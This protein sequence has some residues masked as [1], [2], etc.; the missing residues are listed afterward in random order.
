MYM[1]RV[2]I[3]TNLPSSRRALA[4]SNR[5]HAM[6]AGCF[7]MAAEAQRPLWRID[8]LDESTYLLLVSSVAPDF[9]VLL[10]QL[11]AANETEAI[12]KDYDAFLSSLHNGEAL[13]FRITANPVHSVA[14]NTEN[15]S[16]GKVL[17]HVTVE[18]QKDWLLSRAEK[19]GFTL[20]GFDVV[21]RGVKKFQRQRKTVT[22][23]VAT[24][25]GLLVVDK[26]EALQFAL[27][28]GLGRAKAYGCG[29]LTVARP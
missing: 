5:L 27:I 20:Q 26:V 29:L 10:P 8:T 6:I 13:R 18:Q 1:S 9:D 3:N 24:Y 17:G 28:N 2:R 12:V 7:D 21:S 11:S 4:D 16:R 14:R 23:S 15:S 25:E 22:L 19:N